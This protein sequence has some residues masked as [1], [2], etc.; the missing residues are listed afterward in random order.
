M[1][2]RRPAATRTASPARSEQDLHS[3]RARRSIR[4]ESG[5]QSTR[6]QSCQPPPLLPP[7]LLLLLPPPLPL[8]LGLLP[9]LREG[10]E[11]EVEVEARR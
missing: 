11:E 7:L 8:L 4:R 1:T 9:L 2:R 5:S 10:W 6:L 3:L